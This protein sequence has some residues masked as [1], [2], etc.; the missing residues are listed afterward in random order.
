VPRVVA[1]PSRYRSSSIQSDDYDECEDEDV[2]VYNEMPVYSA[3]PVS[4]RAPTTTIS[5]APVLSIPQK[6]SVKSEKSSAL[7][8]RPVAAGKAMP[9]RSHVSRSALAPPPM[10]KSL[11]SESMAMPSMSSYSMIEPSLEVLGDMA[12]P[13]IVDDEY[14]I[15]PP[16]VPLPSVAD[17]EGTSVSKIFPQI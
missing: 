6:T 8:P 11:A 17:N 13:I 16:P 7:A 5:L 3:M 10:S 14:E 1:S 4:R 12:Y 15:L 9:S 2:P